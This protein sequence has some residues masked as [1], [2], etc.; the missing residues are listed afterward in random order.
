M[1]LFVNGCVRE[2][3]RTLELAREVLSTK[4]DEI[5]EVRLYPDGADGLNRETLLL[6]DEYLSRGDLSHPLFSKAKQFAKAD[7]IV[8]AAPFWDLMFPA[9]VRAY[10][11]EVSVSSITFRY[12]EKGVPEGL[13]RAKQLTYVTT[14]GGPIF[15]NFG[16]EY[17]KAL[18][19]NFYGI[20]S[21]RL[22]KAEGLDIYGANPDEIMKKAKSNLS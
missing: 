21:V 3:S 10:F 9:K 18:C 17:I 8:V 7:E 2:Q 14:S 4:T 1:L 20:K 13:C 12:T 11:E 15:Q 19:E 22:V 16:F 6:R 5:T